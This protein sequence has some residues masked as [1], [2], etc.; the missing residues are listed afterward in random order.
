[1]RLS[2]TI[3]HT[4][5]LLFQRFERVEKLLYHIIATFLSSIRVTQS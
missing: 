3:H 1:M 4:T 2:T 5:R